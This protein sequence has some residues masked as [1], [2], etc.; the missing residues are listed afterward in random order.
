MFNK[1]TSTKI[2]RKSPFYLKITLVLYISLSGGVKQPTAHLTGSWNKRTH[3]SLRLR[4]SD[5]DKYTICKTRG[6]EVF[7]GGCLNR[8]GEHTFV[9]LP[10]ET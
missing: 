1:R 2:C 10:A 4:P 9:F 8:E 7:N 3:K 5:R 6:A